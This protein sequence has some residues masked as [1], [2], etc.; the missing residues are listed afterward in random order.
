M[1]MVFKTQIKV[2]DMHYRDERALDLMREAKDPQTNICDL[3]VGELAARL[4]C[5]RN[6][7]TA[8]TDRLES[9]GHIKKIRAAT[10]GR[11]KFEVLCPE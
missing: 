4:D 11:L 1:N 7:V 9:A 2:T 8:I 5:H 6:T 3:K 10:H